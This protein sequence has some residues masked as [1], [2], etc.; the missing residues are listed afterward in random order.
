MRLYFFMLLLPAVFVHCKEQ[1]KPKLQPHPSRL[2][3]SAKSPDSF[4]VSFETTKGV[5]VMKAVRNWSPLGV[6][7]F[8][9]LA[10]NGYYTDCVIYRVASTAS[11]E[12]GFVV[13]F[14]LANS[15]ELNKAWEKTGIKDEPVVQRHIKG[16]VNF[17]RG[18]PHTRS[19]ELAI[20]LTPA[21]QFDTVSYNGV[22]GFPTIAE[23]VEG[24]TVLELLNKKYGNTVFDNG[25]S[26]LKG[27]EYFDRVYPG[28]DRILS[29]AVIKE[30]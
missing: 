1:V 7:R 13:Q 26:I 2:N 27:R 4:L 23:V 14:G 15:I 18:G 22:I 16:S 10:K 20:S 9:I 24:V 28:L 3:L 21:N 5:F 6:D 11:F 25:D 8:Y 17:A 30:W 29:V 19:V 12:G